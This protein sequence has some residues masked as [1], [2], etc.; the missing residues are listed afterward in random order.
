LFEDRRYRTK[1]LLSVG[2][3]EVALCYANYVAT[4]TDHRLFIYDAANDRILSVKLDYH[5]E[6]V[7][8]FE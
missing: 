3:D 6:E 1:P 8:A 5:A 2:G 4:Y 7:V